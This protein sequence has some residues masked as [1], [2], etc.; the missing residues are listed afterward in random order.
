MISYFSVNNAINIFLYFAL[1]VAIL[2]SGG[3]K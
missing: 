1:I 2:I 3:N